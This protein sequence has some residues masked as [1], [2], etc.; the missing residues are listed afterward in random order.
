M[1]PRPGSDSAVS[2]PP[3]IET[4]RREI[5]SPSPVPPNRRVVEVSACVN[6]S[7]SCASCSGAIPIPVSLTSH[8]QVHVAVVR[9]VGLD[10]HRHLAE[11]R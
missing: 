8:A 11:R 7:N 9:A 2:S 4:S 3:M 1:L 10:P 5:A 6:G